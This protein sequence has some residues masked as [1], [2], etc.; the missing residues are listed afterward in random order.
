VVKIELRK[1]ISFGKNSYVVSLPKKWVIKNKLKKGAFISIIEDQ[2]GLLLKSHDNKPKVEEP[3]RITISAE[4]KNLDV[5]RTEITSA[6]LEGYVIIEV[7][8]KN[9]KDN[10]IEIRDML[11]GF[12]GLEIINQSLSRIVAKD[13]I[14]INEIKI[15]TLIRRMDNIT[16]SMMEDALE[17]FDGV[18]HAESM[19]HIDDEVNRLHFFTYRIIRMGLTDVRIANN[20]GTTPLKLHS[21]HT[22]TTLIERIAD[23]TKKICRY[24]N[25]SK[26]GKKWGLE[27]KGIFNDIK[28]SYFD[29]MKAHYTQDNEIALRIEST[30]KKNVLACDDIFHKHKHEDLTL[31]NEKCKGVCDFRPACGAT[32]KIIENMKEISYS[33]KYIARTII[34]GG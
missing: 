25:D 1:L 17:C 13:L 11:R 14:N 23:S 18:D 22:V 12:A 34:G 4:N 27:L 21:D 32:I 30:N 24:L 8:S 2:D 26:L 33:V 16:R 6:Y 29:V 31:G 7:S 19:A 9:L 5:I 20:L 15:K 10:S 28:Q 3:R